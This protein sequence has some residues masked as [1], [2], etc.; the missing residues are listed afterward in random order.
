MFFLPL[1]DDNSVLRPAFIVW[2]IIAACA[3]VFLWQFSLTPEAREQASIAFGM[4]PAHVFGNAALP[5]HLELLPAW[6][7][8]FSYMFLHGGWMHLIGNMWFL[9]IFGDNVEDAMGRTRFTIFYVVAGVVAA[10]AQS[11]I[12]PMSHVPMIGAS[13]AIAGVLGAYIVLYPRANVRILMFFFFFI[14]I[15]NVPAVF[16]LGAWFLLQLISAERSVG[17]DAGVA[18]WAHVGG[19]LCGCFL[20]PLFKRGNVPLFGEARSRA[21][22]VSGPGIRGAGRIPNVIPPGEDRRADSPWS[23]RSW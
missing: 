1:S 10:V 13:G 14:R 16:V 12:N 20:L 21:F 4:I 6:A 2:V 23:R 18:F 17:S 22:A 9:R 5:R 15:I 11:A 19:F 3:V 8:L 7:T